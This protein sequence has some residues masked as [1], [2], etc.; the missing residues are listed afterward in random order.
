MISARQQNGGSLV[1]STTI[2]IHMVI[3]SI[4]NEPYNGAFRDYYD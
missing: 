2:L 1:N 4:V 3:L